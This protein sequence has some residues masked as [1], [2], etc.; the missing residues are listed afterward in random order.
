MR[1]ALRDF[2]RDGSE[3]AFSK[4][5]A[6]YSPMVLAC[7][8]RCGLPGSLAEEVAQDVFT[9]FVRRGRDIPAGA[10]LA[11]W[12][13]RTCVK[14]S[15]NAR[16]K[17]AR[18][19]AAIDGFT[20]ELMTTDPTS[21]TTAGAME[22]LEDI[23]REILRLPRADREVIVGRYLL[24]KTSRELAADLGISAESAKKRA[25]RAV[26]RLRGSLRRRR[27]MVFSAGGLASAL[28]TLSP[29]PVSASSVSAIASAALSA[30]P[31]GA[32]A[33]SL[34]SLN[35]TFTYMKAKTV[36]IGLSRRRCLGDGGLPG[37]QALG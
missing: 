15:A 33:L 16:R 32:A 6:R 28:A 5:V 24:G 3:E 1:D 10:A 27:G 30:G 13:H 36:A 23:D 25:Q 35:L 17:E 4:I 2:W 22:A 31:A 29:A 19:G 8:R 7:A 20:R 21:G 37:N 34:T 14:I 9:T 26:E 11:A 18:Y 12:L